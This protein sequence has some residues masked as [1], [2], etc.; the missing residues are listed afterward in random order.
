MQTSNFAIP[1]FGIAL[2]LMSILQLLIYFTFLKIIILTFSGIR[3]SI[4]IKSFIAKLS[5]KCALQEIF[6]RACLLFLSMLRK[7]IIKIIYF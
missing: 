6:A 7:Y 4:P 2:S 1:F 5:V 3:T